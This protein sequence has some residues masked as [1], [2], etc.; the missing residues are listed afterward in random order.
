MTCLLTWLL[1]F[2]LEGAGITGTNVIEINELSS[3]AWALP[4]LQHKLDRLN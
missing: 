2:E 3:N 4:D 1:L